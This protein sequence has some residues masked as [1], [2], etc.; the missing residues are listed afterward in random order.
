MEAITVREEG[1]DSP[2]IGTL[3]AQHDSLFNKQEKPEFETK[4]KKC[5]EEHF[6]VDVAYNI[7]ELNWEQLRSRGETQFTIEVLGDTT[8]VTTITLERTWVY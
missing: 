1:T 2:N 3:V 4:F 8:Y 5:L 6:D 7:E